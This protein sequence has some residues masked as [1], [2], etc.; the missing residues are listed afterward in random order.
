MEER[1]SIEKMLPLDQLVGK[2]A[3]RFP[4][5]DGL[6]GKPTVLFLIGD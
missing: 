1:I 6:V 3:V 5:L 4:P 2:P